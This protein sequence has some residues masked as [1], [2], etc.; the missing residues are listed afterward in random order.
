MNLIMT[1][2]NEIYQV[3]KIWYKKHYFKKGIFKRMFVGVNLYGKDVT[4]E[5]VLL[6]TFEDTAEA[7]AELIKLT[8]STDPI[9]TV[10]EY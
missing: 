1:Q 4:G 3:T 8:K 7:R 2:D 5:K 6:G 9:K 10:T